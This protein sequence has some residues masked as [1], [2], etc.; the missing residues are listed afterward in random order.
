MRTLGHI[1]TSAGVG[2]FTYHRYKSA[3]AGIASFLVGWLIDLDH[4]VDYVRAHG[5]RP[6]WQRE[7]SV[8]TAAANVIGRKAKDAAIVI[9]YIYQLSLMSAYP[10]HRLW[11]IDFTLHFPSLF[12]LIVFSS[13]AHRAGNCCADKWR[14]VFQPCLISVTKNYF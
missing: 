9:Y 6:N 1:I 12:S 7:F 4:I 10:A 14:H 5:W 2:L 3:G 11:N 8:V 13:G